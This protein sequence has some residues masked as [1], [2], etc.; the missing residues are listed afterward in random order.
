MK[1]T[2]IAVLTFAF[3]TA[4]FGQE[5]PS[6]I[7]ELELKSNTMSASAL[8]SMFG[9][10]HANY[11]KVINEGKNEY[12]FMLGTFGYEDS[13]SGDDAWE[14]GLNDG[15]MYG[16][17][18]ATGGKATYRTYRKGNAKGLFYQAQLRMMMLS[19]GYKSGTNDWKDVNTPIID[20]GVYVGYK[21]VPSFLFKGR[22]L[23]EAFAGGVYSIFTPGDGN[24]TLTSDEGEKQGGDGFGP[25]FNIY[26]G[27]SF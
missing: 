2:L 22:L 8:W 25:D 15:Y 27:F 23:V 18:G 14:T 1:N 6:A 9:F 13:Y 20:P 17:K 11:G 10:L 19:W 24:V 7:K 3:A 16:F 4:G 12:Q 21:Y 26:I 5:E